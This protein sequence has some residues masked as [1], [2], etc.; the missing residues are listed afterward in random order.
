MV[1]QFLA[2]LLLMA[3]WTGYVGLLIAAVLYAGQDLVKRAR[4]R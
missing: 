4:R 3:V 2:W 1:I